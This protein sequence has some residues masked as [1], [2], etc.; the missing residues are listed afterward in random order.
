MKKIIWCLIVMV[1]IS[2]MVLAQKGKPKLPPKI[3]S[4]EQ[5]GFQ[6]GYAVVKITMYNRSDNS[7]WIDVHRKDGPGGF[8]NQI[9]DTINAP[10][11][12]GV[13]VIYTD[14]SAPTGVMCLYKVRERNEVGDSGWSNVKQIITKKLPGGNEAPTADC[15]VNPDTG[16]AEIT[17]FHYSIFG[18]DPDGFIKKYL[19]EYGDNSTSKESESDHV[20]KN[21]GKYT[22]K[23]TVW[24]NEGASASADCPCVTVNK[25]IPSPE[26]DVELTF[27]NVKLTWF[28]D[29]SEEPEWLPRIIIVM[30]TK[31]PKP[32]GYW[33]ILKVSYGINRDSHHKKILDMSPAQEISGKRIKFRYADEEVVK[34]TLVYYLLY[35]V[36]GSEVEPCNE[37]V[38]YGV[39]SVEIPRNFEQ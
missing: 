11:Q 38:L 2:G 3:T 24:D 25:Q 14:N 30:E 36:C 32:D 21:S 18:N 26:C 7:L 8:A 9:I 35:W 28:Q 13:Q 34:G 29:D 17:P 39:A 16:F 1:L 23:V 31:E 6:D 4:V 33:R 37:G 22:A 5:V 20:Y 19:I 15:S 27:F 10:S 12:A